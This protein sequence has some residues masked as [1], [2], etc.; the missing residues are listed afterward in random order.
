MRLVDVYTV[1]LAPQILYEA[2]QARL[3]EPS[4]NISHTE[5]PS[6]QDHCAFFDSKPY[7]G[8]YFIEEQHGMV[9]IC[10]ITRNNELG[11]YILRSHRGKGYGK[12]ALRQLIAQHEPMPAIPGV[13]PCK[14]VAR[15]SPKNTASKCLFHSLGFAHVEDTL[16]L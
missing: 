11:I 4:T 6:Y 2:L 7:R 13:R 10:Y 12:M 8:W 1:T 15:I 14:Y 5:M 9:G 3:E 16:T